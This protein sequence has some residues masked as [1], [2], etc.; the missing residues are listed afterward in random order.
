M[1]SER[2]KIQI[3]NGSGIMPLKIKDVHFVNVTGWNEW[4]AQKLV[5]Q[6]K[7]AFIGCYDY[8]FSRDIEPRKHMATA[9]TIN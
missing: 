3:F 5:F 1:R 2:W 7:I 9:R 4:V 8:E 6:N